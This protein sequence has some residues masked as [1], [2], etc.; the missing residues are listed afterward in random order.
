MN[1]QDLADMIMDVFNKNR[2]DKEVLDDS[3][4]FYINDCGRKFLVDCS[5][6]SGLLHGTTRIYTV[7]GDAGRYATIK[8]KNGIL[9]GRAYQYANDRAIFRYRFVDG[10]Q[11]SI[12]F[13]R[14]WFWRGSGCF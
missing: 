9:H 3:Y 10:K 11:T 4:T 13:R 12:E 1:V 8:F 7:S 2:D 5:T 6:S 14:G